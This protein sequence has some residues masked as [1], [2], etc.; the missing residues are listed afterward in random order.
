MLPP[1]CRNR[2]FRSLK[3]ALRDVFPVEIR[4]E[5]A[6]LRLLQVR[7]DC[8]EALKGGQTASF[9]QQSDE[10]WAVNL[11]S[12]TL[13]AEVSRVARAVEAVRAPRRCRLRRRRRA[14]RG[15]R[16]GGKPCE[17]HRKSRRRLGSR[18][19]WELLRVAPGR[20]EP[21]EP[22]HSHMAHASLTR[23]HGIQYTVSTS[24]ENSSLHGVWKR[25]V[26]IRRSAIIRLAP[27]EVYTPKRL[28]YATI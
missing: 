14:P 12:P 28:G 6:D 20:R 21:F 1:R 24:V 10:A 19:L 3:T 25:T 5:T 13:V 2:S 22:A 26:L 4:L 17:I 27:I 16:G 18:E 23:F 8:F 11:F 7:F 15:P 9:L